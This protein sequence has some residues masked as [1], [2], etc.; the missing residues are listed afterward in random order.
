MS[1]A[2]TGKVIATR[3]RQV[4]GMNVKRIMTSFIGRLVV[5]SNFNT[6]IRIAHTTIKIHFYDN[7]NGIY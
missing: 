5:D 3:A 2:M 6:D 1:S 4:R 7:D